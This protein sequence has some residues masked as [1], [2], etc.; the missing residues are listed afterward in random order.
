M[1]EKDSGIH[2]PQRL[3]YKISRFFYPVTE[4]TEK[5]TKSI[6]HRM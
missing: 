4:K 1:L 3:I 5:I 6:T 2:K